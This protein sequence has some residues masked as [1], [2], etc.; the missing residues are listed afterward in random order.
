MISPGI[1]NI[2]RKIYG[3]LVLLSV[4]TVT[5]KYWLREEVIHDK[6]H[7]NGKNHGNEE[8]CYAFRIYLCEWQFVW[9][10]FLHV[11]CGMEY[12]RLIG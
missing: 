1:S 4:R 2:I 7:K 3:K 12:P 6:E 10:S 8:K 11:L 9:N 5:K